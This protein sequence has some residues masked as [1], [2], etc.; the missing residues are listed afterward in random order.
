VEEDWWNDFWKR[1]SQYNEKILPHYLFTT[2]ESFSALAAKSGCRDFQRK[3][4]PRAVGRPVKS[5][6]WTVLNLPFPSPFINQHSCTTLCILNHI[7]VT[8]PTRFGIRWH[9]LQGDLSKCK[10][11][12]TSSDYKHLNGRPIR[13][14]SF[15]DL[16]KPTGHVMHQQFYIQQLYALPTLYLCVLYLSE[17]KQRLVPLTA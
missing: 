10:L 14:R 13:D 8:A 5:R 4:I 9:H 15:F 1:T 7:P 6:H 11:F 2:N 16:L 3:T 17:N 12:A